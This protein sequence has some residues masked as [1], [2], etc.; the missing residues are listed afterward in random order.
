MYEAKI[1]TAGLRHLVRLPDKVRQSALETAFDPLTENPHR[2]S[3]PLCD[4]LEGLRSV[5]RG[6]YRI[7]DEIL[8]DETVVLIHRFE[9]RRHADRLT[10]GGSDGPR[11]C[12]WSDP[13][14][15]ID[16]TD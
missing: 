8:E 1:A 13:S 12:I 7:V 2:A 3:K 11:H 9:H 5:R 6:S 10:R 14:P 15:A 16:C 4:E